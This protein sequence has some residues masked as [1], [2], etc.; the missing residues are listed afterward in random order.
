[1]QSENVPKLNNELAKF[2]DLETLGIKEDEPSVYDKFTQDV[3]FNSERYEA[4]LPFKEEHPL[5]PDNYSVCVKRLGSLIG[6]LQKTPEILQ[7]YHKV[8]QDQITS[9]VVEEI[10]GIEVKPPGQV[11]YLPHKEVVRNDKD[12]TK[13][14][15]VYDASAR[16]YGPSL[17]DCLYAGPSLT[18]LI[19]NI[20][21]RF[22][23]YPVAVSADIEKAFLNIAIS[24]EHRDYL[25]FLWV[26][27][28]RFTRVVFSLTSSPFILNATI[29]HHVS[30]YTTSDPEFVKEVMRSLYVDDF[31]SGSWNVQT[32]LQLS[33]KVKT[34]LSDG[35]F[36]MRKWT[37]NSK[38][39]ME[40][41]R[42]DARK[43]GMDPLPEMETLP[44]E[45]E[46]I[47]MILCLNRIIN[48][49]DRRGIQLQMY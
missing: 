34:R 40:E 37:S 36:N 30:Q 46:L 14:R 6:R 33:T 35:G 21:I 44:P 24:P 45:K 20:L 32:V 17:N 48:Y 12:T 18:P 23:I 29:K 27:P 9:G 28:L 39:L 19:F 41:L 42:K 13:L 5:L 16:N 47:S 8:I 11:H 25:R 15:V 10:K 7:E 2:W 43:F 38:E 26:R 49:S 4:K 1:M 22:R 31:A 3:D